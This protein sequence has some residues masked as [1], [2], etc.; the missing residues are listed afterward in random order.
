MSGRRLA[1]WAWVATPFLLLALGSWALLRSPWPA[2]LGLTLKGRHVFVP[3]NGS[4]LG[5]GLL[6]LASFVAALV[7]SYTIRRRPEPG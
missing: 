1:R 3:L 6:A 4:S 7:I 5:L 2:V